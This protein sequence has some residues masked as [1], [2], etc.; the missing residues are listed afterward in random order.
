MRAPIGAFVLSAL[1]FCVYANTTFYGNTCRFFNEGTTWLRGRVRCIHTLGA[2]L[3][4]V[5]LQAS[6]RASVEYRRGGAPFSVSGTGL[7]VFLRAGIVD[8]AEKKAE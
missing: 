6:A 5:F 8:G 3:L 4:P 1:I 2:F 7:G